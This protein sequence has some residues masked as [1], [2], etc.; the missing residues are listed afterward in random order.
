MTFLGT[1]G[2]FITAFFLFVRFVPIISI[3]E[4][5]ELL[6]NKAGGRSGHSVMENAT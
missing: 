4:I 1:I 5:R 3:T 2:F 6:P